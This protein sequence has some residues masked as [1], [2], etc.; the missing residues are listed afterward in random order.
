MIEKE[1]HFREMDES[2]ENE[3]EQPSPD[4]FRQR[5]VSNTASLPAEQEVPK[6]VE[7]TS[8]ALVSFEKLHELVGKNISFRDPHTQPNRTDDPYRKAATIKQNDDNFV[9]AV[10]RGRYYPYYT[11]DRQNIFALDS[12]EDINRYEVKLEK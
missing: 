5:R 11:S 9:I 7:Q 4:T 6:P 3:P 2:I 10:D 8:E 1:P 12:Q